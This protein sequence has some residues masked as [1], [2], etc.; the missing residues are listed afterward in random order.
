MNNSEFIDI[1][2]NDK[3]YSTMKENLESLK[4]K[5]H[6]PESLSFEKIEPCE[7]AL[8]LASEI[9]EYSRTKGYDSLYERF[10]NSNIDELELNNIKKIL[11][12]TK[13]YALYESACSL[14]KGNLSELAL[15]KYFEILTNYIPEGSIY[16]ERPAILLE[17]LKRY[18]ESIK[19][20]DLAIKNQQENS[21]HFP[22]KDFEYRK[23]RLVRKLNKNCQTTNKIENKK[24][25]VLKDIKVVPQDNNLKSHENIKFPDWYVSISFGKSTSK[26]FPQAVALAKMAPQYIENEIEGKILHQAVYS[27][28]SN[29]YLQFIKLY[30]LV[31]KWKSCFVIINGQVIDRKIIG[32]LNYCYGDKCRS[33]NPDFCYGASYMTGNPFGCH[34]IQ[35]SRYNNPWWNFGIFDTS[36]IWHVDKETILKRIIQYSQPYKLCPCFSLDKIKEVLTQLPDTINPQTN[37]AWQRIGDSTSP[38]SDTISNPPSIT[39]GI[40]VNIEP[41]YTS[42]ENDLITYDSSPNTSDNAD[43]TY[44][45]DSDTNDTD[46]TSHSS[47]DTNDGTD[48]TC[49]SVSDTN[50]GR[51]NK[52]GCLTTTIIIIIIILFLK[53]IL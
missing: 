50:V 3:K 45:Y 41:K 44:S 40:K 11:E 6:S 33:G 5:I 2:S 12:H 23:N 4:D 36:G 53:L 28:N 9:Y 26:N 47:F 32:G 13:I 21:L 24:Q 27:H 20:C 14:E 51:N 52:S 8:K 30:E 43:I 16:Y 31:S 7:N 29:E 48:V 19:V 38:T 46:I 34:R 42:K 37:E 10:F 22:K 25:E 35:I 17:K 18:D 1:I 49:S 15:E 39:Y